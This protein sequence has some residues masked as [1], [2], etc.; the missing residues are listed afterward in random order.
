MKIVQIA[1]EIFHWNLMEIRLIKPR[2]QAEFGGRRVMNN[3]RTARLTAVLECQYGKHFEGQHIQVSDETGGILFT[4]TIFDE[5]LSRVQDSSSR[6]AVKIEAF[7]ESVQENQ[8]KFFCRPDYPNCRCS[9]DIRF[10][11]PSIH[12][13]LDESATKEYPHRCPHCGGPSYNPVFGGKPDCKARC[14]DG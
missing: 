11:R 7:G 8:I 4:G 1:E 5:E 6:C 12:G 2:Y 13:L 9:P 3:D 14:Q 10:D